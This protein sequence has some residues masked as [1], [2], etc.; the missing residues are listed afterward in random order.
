M[1]QGLV[2]RGALSVR[3]SLIIEMHGAFEGAHL[4]LIDSV[5]L[6]YCFY[7]LKSGRCAYEYFYLLAAGINEAT[8]KLQE[9]D[10]EEEVE[11]GGAWQDV[12]RGRED[13]GEGEYEGEVGEAIACRG[14]VRVARIHARCGIAACF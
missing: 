10:G 11:K 8:D 9:G 4:S 2:G 12:E 1:T 6:F 14:T 13:E 3:I 5:Y 7:C